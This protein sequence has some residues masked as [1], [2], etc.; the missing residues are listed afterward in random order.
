MKTQDLIRLVSSISSTSPKA[1]TTNLLQVGQNH[2]Q[3]REV[4]SADPTLE[5][6]LKLPFD[7]VVPKGGAYFFVPSITTLKT[8]LTL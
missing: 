6:A 4:F 8:K 7:F 3:T 2:G 1:I 5:N